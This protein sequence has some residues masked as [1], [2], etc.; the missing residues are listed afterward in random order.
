MKNT[1]SHIYL[2]AKGHYQRNDVIKDMKK[3]I[4]ERCNIDAEYIT[5]D[6]IL[7]VVLPI[8]YKHIKNNEYKFIDFISNLKPQNLWKYGPAKEENFDI[9]IIRNCL[10][11]LSITQVKEKDGKILIELDE[12]DSH[13]LPLATNK[14]GYL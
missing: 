3:I 13:I 14:K 10:S 12:A 8:A 2:Y 5:I 9:I 4:T 11:V 6:D 7:S 1:D